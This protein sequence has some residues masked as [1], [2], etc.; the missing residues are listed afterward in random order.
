M[1]HLVR[2]VGFDDLAGERARGN[3]PVSNSRPWELKSSRNSM[4]GGGSAYGLGPWS[5]WTPTS[6]RSC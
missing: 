5:R 4:T 3:R 2:W 6:S 1:P